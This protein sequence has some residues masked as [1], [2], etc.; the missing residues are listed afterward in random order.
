M[1][2]IQENETA[3]GKGILSRFI[4]QHTHMEKHILS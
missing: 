3:W 2:Y 1:I 4:C